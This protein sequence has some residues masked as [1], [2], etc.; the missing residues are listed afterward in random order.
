MGVA[1]RLGGGGKRERGRVNKDVSGG[2][3]SLFY[4]GDVGECRVVIF[5]L[6]GSISGRDERDGMGCGDDK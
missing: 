5:G 4:F 1:G 3:D 6:M 2:G